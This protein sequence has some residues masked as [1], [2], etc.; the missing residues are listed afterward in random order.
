MM[1]HDLFRFKTDDA[2]LLAKGGSGEPA[3][4]DTKT[5]YEADF[6]AWAKQQ[7]EA[8]RVAARAGSNRQLDWEN[9]AEE[10]ED[11]ARSHTRGLRAHITR[12]VQHLA[13]LEHSPAVDPRKNWRR[14]VRLARMQIEAL[15]EDNPSLRREVNRVVQRAI[16]DGIELAILDLEEYAEI[17]A[18]D[19]ARI[20]RSSYTSEQILGDWFP[21]EPPRGAE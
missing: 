13:K 10:I 15:L 21:P 2:I 16:K 7:A 9:L 6:F 19:F 1:G 8:L 3:M 18:T 5:L 11:L 20:R 4:S 14:S 12:I 17:D